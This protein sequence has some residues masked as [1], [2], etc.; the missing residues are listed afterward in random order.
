MGNKIPSCDNLA[1]MQQW[2]VEC[3]QNWGYYIRKGFTSISDSKLKYKL[4]QTH[5]LASYIY[6]ARPRFTDHESEDTTEDVLD[7]AD[8]N[9]RRKR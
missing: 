7:D 6:S 9:K 1:L 8:N 5:F 4:P 3:L 2:A